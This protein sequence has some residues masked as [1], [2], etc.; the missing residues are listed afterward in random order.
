MLA[1]GS[2]LFLLRATSEHLLL[3]AGTRTLLR[4]MDVIETVV[5]GQLDPVRIQVE[6]VGR[7]MQSAEF[8]LSNPDQVA[9]VL[10]G[11]LASTP[12]VRVLVYCDPDLQ[13][14]SV[15]RDAGADSFTI[16]RYNSSDSET[17]KSMDAMMRQADGA[18][19]GDLIS[20]DSI[21]RTLLNVRY[22]I[23]RDGQYLGFLV[24]GVTTREM[25]RVAANIRELMGAST[26]L[27]L[28]G[29]QILAHPALVDDERSKRVV[30]LFEQLTISHNQHSKTIIRDIDTTD[31]SDALGGVETFE[32]EYKGKEYI[33][34]TRSLDDYGDPP[35]AIG[36]YSTAKLIRAPMQLL[37]TA[38]A[39][40]FVVLAA[41]LGIAAWLSR[42]V[43]KPIRRV[44]AGVAQI[45]QLDLNDVNEM[46]RSPL[47]EVDEL[48]SSFN[49]MLSALRAFSTYVPQRLANL[50]V[51]GVV[52]AS[53]ASEERELTVMFTDIAGF[54]TLSEG[55][56][57]VEVADFINEHLTMLAECV[58]GTGGTIDKYIGD[59]LMA[60]WGAP[61]RMEN[62]A[63]A[64]CRAA[65]LMAQRL[66]EDNH[67]RMAAG[68]PPIR[69]RIGIH[70]GP[71]VVGNIGAPGRIN[72][73]VVG[74]TVNASQRLE[75][76][77]KQIDADAEFIALLSAA[78]A[79]H[80]EDEFL[81]HP[82]G[83][84][85]LRGKQRDLSVLRLQV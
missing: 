35:L 72:Y 40:S 4:T 44:S 53:V 2:V 45:G 36:A 17:A 74:D 8:D 75:S 12:Q 32:F 84:F 58:E 54:T 60:F 62:T 38:G 76:L 63:K 33:G 55:M 42:A 78:T 82:E 15:V 73:T 71:L 29:G 10:Q 28:G 30:T 24:A 21:D 77:G 1:G 9:D 19:W 16:D 37:Y 70:T 41:A 11:A 56:D 59:A 5:R 79:A 65:T 51:Q 64:A 27:T 85:Q 61:Q 14:V 48:A 39:I 25:S 18:R 52:G 46:A 3:N 50:V 83:E 31:A 26:Y 66:K 68:K 43:A 47:R 7:M 80:L 81:L 13:F 67:Q 22:P 6:S 57:A 69:L 20:A 23:R 34:F 49:R